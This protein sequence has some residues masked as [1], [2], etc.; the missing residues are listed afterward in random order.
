MVMIAI[1]VMIVTVV[2]VVVVIVM[3]AALEI[4]RRVLAQAPMRTLRG[5]VRVLASAHGALPRRGRE[6]RGSVGARLAARR[7]TEDEDEGGVSAIR[8]TRSQ[9][10]S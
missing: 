2:V 4:A 8:T 1:V 3:I 6:L 10:R 9:L 7:G 5:G